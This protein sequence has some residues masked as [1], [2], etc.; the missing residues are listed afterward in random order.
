M[1][2]RVNKPTVTEFAGETVS[3]IVKVLGVDDVAAGCVID[4]A[5]KTVDAFNDAVGVIVILGVVVEVI[6]GVVVEVILGVMVEVILGVMV[7]F[8]LAVVTELVVIVVLSIGVEVVDVEQESALT[9]VTLRKAVAVFSKE[10][11]VTLLSKQST[12]R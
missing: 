3:V 1:L 6:L 7:E 4:E 2:G 9:N 11:A 8:I 10:G 5:L 12:R